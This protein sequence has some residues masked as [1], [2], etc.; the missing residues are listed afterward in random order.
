MAADPATC[1]TNAACPH[2]RRQ[3]DKPQQSDSGS[4][5]ILS[6][7]RNETRFHFRKRSSRHPLPGMRPTLTSQTRTWKTSTVS[8][9]APATRGV[10]NDCDV[11]EDETCHHREDLH[12]SVTRV[13]RVTADRF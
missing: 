10:D 12:P 7:R 9:V 5:R 13:S 4:W 6:L 3:V 1:P 2:N 8:L 11:R